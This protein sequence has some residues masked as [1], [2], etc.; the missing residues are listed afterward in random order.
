[1]RSARLLLL[2]LVAVS[3]LVPSFAFATAPSKSS[4]T[5]IHDDYAKALAEAKAKNVP[6]FVEAWA[7]WCHSCRSMGAY[8]F[9][10]PKLGKYSSRFVWV[11]IDIDKAQNAPVKKKFVIDGVPS[12]F[13][14]DPTDDTVALRW[15]GS[16]TVPQL[17]DILDDGSKS[18]AKKSAQRVDK[19]LA[20]ADKLFADGKNA[21]AAAAYSEALAAAP[22]NWSRYGRT[23]ESLL[24]ALQSSKQYGKCVV[25]AEGSYPQLKNSSSGM[26]VAAIGL[27]C[28]VNLPKED[29]T[30]VATVARL[31]AIARETMDNAK[32][33]VAADDRSGLYITM[34]DARSDAGDEAGAKALAKEWAAFLEGEAAKASTPE[35]R[36][37]F[38]S[39]RL[40]AYIE[41]GEPQRAIPMLEQSQRDFPEDYNPPA[42]LA[43]A[44]KAMGKYEESI[45]YADL[46]LSRAY[47]PRRLTIFRTKVDAQ[48]AMGDKD[49]AR[50]TMR[51]AVA[52]A[53][54]LP[55][56][57]RNDRTIASLK[58]KLASLDQMPA[59]VQ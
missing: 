25:R 5:F 27:D 4:I 54:A 31:E 22:K 23:T 34:M 49:G 45:R 18:V 8:V 53:E 10:D 42:R 1:M 17:M 24:F 2:A 48:A 58:E 33:V 28:A 20:K 32:V 40:S 50:A 59:A 41:L 12:F 16:A 36:A 47:G 6:L 56:G 35:A 43:A 3:L 14:V 29:A 15:L 26:N 44:Y 37:V 30:R 39:H 52:E 38:D 55:D 9:P 13:I 11:A 7:T 21:E 51:A 46:A 19:S 57:Q